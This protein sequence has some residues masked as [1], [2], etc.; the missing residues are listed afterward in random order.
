M[1][2]VW[3]RHGTRVHGS[4]NTVLH[5]CNLRTPVRHENE[6]SCTY[7]CFISFDRRMS[8]VARMNVSFHMTSKWL[9]LH[10]WIF[11]LFSS[12]CSWCA[13][14]SVTCKWVMSHI[15]MRRVA[16]MNVMNEACCTC[17]E[18]G[19]LH[20]ELNHMCN[21]PHSYVTW[22]LWM[23][24]VAHRTDTDE[25]FICATRL[26]HM[27]AHLC[28]MQMG[29]VD[30]AHTNEACCTYECFVC[31]NSTCSGSTCTCVTCLSRMGERTHTHVRQD[32][33]IDVT[34]LIHMWDMTQS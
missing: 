17:Y 14:T 29:R 23:R 32:W 15:W 27:C 16:H 24:R 4:H 13:R 26:I 22:M 20:I 10:V 7:E 5:V 25:T 28:D 19:V 18:W 2:R 6:S 9:T 3:I 34:R 11:I 31:V 21:T 8:D 33:F 12:A 30:V 1:S